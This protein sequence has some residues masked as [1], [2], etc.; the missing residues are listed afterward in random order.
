MSK[1]ET[2]ED[3]SFSENDYISVKQL[4]MLYRLIG[5]DNNHRRTDAE[6]KVMLAMSH[7]YVAAHTFEKALVGFT[8]VC[9]D[10]YVVQVLDVITHPDYRNRGIA[11]A[12]MDYVTEHL[13]QAN[14]VSVT[15][16]DGSGLANFYQ[17][18]GFRNFE[19]AA[20]MVWKP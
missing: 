14:Y 1:Q 3:I 12:C 10:P 6:T 18:S 2:P 5:W 9:G 13:K 8:R 7:Y 11:N 16:T 17:K 4:N 15:L 20:S 19:K